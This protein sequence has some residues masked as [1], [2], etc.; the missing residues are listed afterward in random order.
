[1]KGNV[2]GKR[3][4]HGIG[5]K[6]LRGRFEILRVIHTK[7]MSNVYEVIDSN[8]G[9]HW[10]IKEIRKSEAGRNDIEYRS[11]IAEAYVMKELSHANIPTIVDIVS[12]EDSVYI[13][14]EYVE[15]V[16]IQQTLNMRGKLDQSIA[17]SFARQICSVVIYLHTRDIPI[18][19]GDMK[20]D[21]VMV[22]S[23]GT[24]K[25]VDFGASVILTED[26]KIITEPIGTK[27]Y[28]PPEQ[29]KKGIP[30]D[31]RSDIYAIGMTLYYMLTGLNPGKKEI[32]EKIKTMPLRE[33]DLNISVGLDR[34]VTKAI[35]E[36]VNER[37]QT[38]EEFLY[39]LQNIDKL[40]SKYN[41]K[42]RNKVSTVFALF[43]LSIVMVIG[44]FIP[45]MLDSN[46]VEA[47]Y[48]RLVKLGEQNS[49]YDIYL[50]AINMFPERMD[51]YLGLIE[52]IKQDGIFSKEEE[53]DILGYLSPVIADKE[54][55]VE[56]DYNRVAFELAKL[57]WFYYE[58]GSEKGQIASVKWFEDAK[59]GGYLAEESDTYYQMG[60]FKRDIAKS[61]AE[62]E[63][64]GMYKVFF[65]NLV[66]A[67][68]F[69]N[70]DVITL[71]LNSM[72]ADC[73]S[74]YAY[75]LKVDGIPKKDVDYQINRLES[76]ITEYK[77]DEDSK[78]Y[79]TY[80][81]LINSLNGLQNKVNIV[82]G[83]NVG[84]VE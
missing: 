66:K 46:R 28:A 79:E 56:G 63:D 68:E 64:R 15:G 14:M 60:S 67:T 11:L 77:P 44:S 31:L 57:Y 9:K 65:D 53:K 3:T 72:I 35:K 34:I 22:H 70:G 83:D 39:D 76:Y 71:Q 55:K 69:K 40:D 84:G 23:D 24:I 4:S 12:E 42:L 54:V 37:Y 1:M 45:R 19:Y 25:L 13:Q 61:I 78:T 20:P 33:Y 18:F 49:D 16:S 50:Q 30:Y 36:D 10:C 38:V 73:I 8:L 6:I 80:E 51:P 62:S 41:R 5:D 32:A 81:S 47:E 58:G 17:I 59:N 75:N 43:I 2:R 21:N 7:G 29:R 52:E 48:T 82:Y 27:G 74:I 26:N